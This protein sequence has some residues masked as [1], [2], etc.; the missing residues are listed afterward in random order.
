MRKAIRRPIL[1]VVVLCLLASVAMTGCDVD[2]DAA[3]T[4]FRSTAVPNIATALGDLITAFL[5][6]FSAVL[7]PDSS[8]SGSS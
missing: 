3:L 1:A 7:T 8:S 5:N 2:W 6:G 4:E